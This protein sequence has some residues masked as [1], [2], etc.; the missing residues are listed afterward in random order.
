MNRKRP[1]RRLQSRRSCS[2]SS[3]ADGIP[4]ELL[5]RALRRSFCISRTMGGILECSLSRR[6]RDYSP[7]ESVNQSSLERSVN[8]RSWPELLVDVYNRHPRRG[9]SKND[10]RRQRS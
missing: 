3:Q 4:M 6:N 7:S 8:L 1:R 5:W 9:S 10:E 2:V